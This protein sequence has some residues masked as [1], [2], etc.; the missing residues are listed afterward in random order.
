M[1]ENFSLSVPAGQ[2]AEPGHNGRELRRVMTSSFVG[3]A[4]EF[5]DFILYATASALVFGPVFF[6][7]LDP[8]LA[9]V[10]SY[11]TF[12]AGYAAR[13]LGGIIF[14]H[15]GDRLGRKKMLITSMT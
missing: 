11:L 8:A 6:S 2:P 4:I 13:P 7:T 14:G 3:S 12:A 1:Q 5:Y 15:F 10:A 9:V